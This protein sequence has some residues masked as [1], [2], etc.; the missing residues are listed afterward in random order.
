MI[1]LGFFFPLFW[2]FCIPTLIATISTINNPTEYM[3][4]NNLSEE[5]KRAFLKKHPW[6]DPN[7]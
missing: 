1:A 4:Y 7:D 5:D 3:G 6:N 2:V